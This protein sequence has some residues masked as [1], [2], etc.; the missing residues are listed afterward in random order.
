M[1]CAEGLWRWRRIDTIQE[2]RNDNI[3]VTVTMMNGITEC[4]GKTYIIVRN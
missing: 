4:F 2:I 1:F 3:L